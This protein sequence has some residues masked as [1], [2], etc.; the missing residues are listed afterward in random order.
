MMNSYREKCIRWIDV[1][2]TYA[3]YYALYYTYR[4]RASPYTILFSEFVR[5]DV[6]V[7]IIARLSIFI[8]IIRICEIENNNSP[9]KLTTIT[10]IQGLKSSSIAILMTFPRNV[11]V[12]DKSGAVLINADPQIKT[13]LIS[14]SVI[15]RSSIPHTGCRAFIIV[16]RVVAIRVNKRKNCRIV[17]L[18]NYRSSNSPE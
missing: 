11:H 3:F 13:S 1:N 10:F 12:I 16:E 9:D 14:T 2:F 17:R 7:R 5:R 8:P 18:Y 15:F 4:K 6:T